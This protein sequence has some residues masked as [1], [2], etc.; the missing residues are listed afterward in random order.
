MWTTHATSQRL[1]SVYGTF[2]DGRYA[3]DTM[4]GIPAP[5]RLADSRHLIGL[6]RIDDGEFAWDTDVAYAVGSATAED[7]AHFITALWAGAEGRTER[8]VRDRVR[9]TAP[10]SSAVLAQLFRVDSISTAHLPDSSTLAA[11]TVTLTPAGVESRFPHFARYMRRY[12]ETSRIRLTLTDREAA[13]FFDFSLRDGRML[14]RVRTRD[15]KLVPL[16]GAARAMPDTLA[17]NGDF[18]LKVRRFTVGFRKYHGDFVISRSEHERAW[19]IIS[20]REPEWVLPLFTETLLRTPL[21]RPFQG[22][23]SSFRISAMDQA[24]RQ[25]LLVRRLHMEVQESAILRFLGRLGA[26]AVSD[27]TGDAEREQYA[28]LKEFFD[29]LLEDLRAQVP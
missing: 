25:T 11:F 29:A 23:G 8:D 10:R 24:G 7:I 15:G 16:S 21:R 6:T 4:S 2:A 18:T 3:L 1:L 14:L 26:I 28:W 22:P 9:A 12:G 20:Q 13:L 27:Y 17:I 5:S 19:T